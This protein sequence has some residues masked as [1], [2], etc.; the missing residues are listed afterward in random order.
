[1]PSLRSNQYI[2][3][4]EMGDPGSEDGVLKQSCYRLERHGSYISEALVECDFALP[5]PSKDIAPKNGICGCC[6]IG[7]THLLGLKI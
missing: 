1:M 2:V 3:S 7:C 5:M 4:E 6:F